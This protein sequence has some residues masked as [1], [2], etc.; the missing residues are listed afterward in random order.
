MFNKFSAAK[1]LINF[2]HYYV[3][4][5]AVTTPQ[6]EK[7]A[8]WNEVALKGELPELEERNRNNKS[9]MR[10]LPLLVNI[11]EQLLGAS[12]RYQKDAVKVHHY[13]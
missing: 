11:S 1:W 8:K 6:E 5:V 10:I 13:L 7:G 9:M 3:L 2:L 4:Q 12:R